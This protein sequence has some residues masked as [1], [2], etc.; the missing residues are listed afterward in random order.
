V[1]AVDVDARAVEVARAQLADPQVAD[2]VEL[3][4]GDLRLVA[5]NAAETGGFDVIWASDVVWPATFDDPAAVVRTMAGA[6]APGGVLAL[7]T[8]N[9]Y[10][11]MLVP[12]HTRLERLVRTASELT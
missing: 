4:V 1:R 5:A 2:L 8:T 12:G 6:L 11:S 7:F 10:Q 3:E 9:Y